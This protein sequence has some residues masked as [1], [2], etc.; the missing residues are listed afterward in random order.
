MSARRIAVVQWNARNR[1][2]VTEIVAE[3]ETEQRREVKQ[4]VTAH[5]LV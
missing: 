3:E 1:G 4:T 5:R 2:G